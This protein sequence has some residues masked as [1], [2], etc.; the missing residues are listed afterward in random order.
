MLKSDALRHAR[1]LQ[2][3]RP[4]AASPIHFHGSSMEPL[5]READELIVREA[6]WSEIGLGDVVV[7]RLKDKYPALRVVRKRGSRLWLIGDNWPGRRFQL[8]REH[9]LGKVVARIRNGQTTPSTGAY[10]QARRAYALARYHAGAR[11]HRARSRIEG[12]RLV[13]RDGPSYPTPPNLQINVSSLCNLKCRMCPYLPVHGDPAHQSYMDEATFASLMDTVRSIGAVHL[14]GSGEPMHNQAL[15]DFVRLIRKADPEVTIDLTTNGTMMN[16]RRAR[17][18]VELGVDKLHVSFDGMPAR[19]GSIRTGMN[20]Q[21]VIE[22]IARLTEIKKASG[23]RRPAIQINY[24]TGYGT[25]HDLVDFVELANEIGVSEIQLLEMQPATAEDVRENLLAG[26]ERDGGGALKE[27]I[28]LA[29]YY[30]I[31]LHL[32]VVSENA[33][34]YPSN[35]HIGEDGEVYPCCYLDYDGRD[36]YYQGSSRR[37]PGTSF[38]NALRDSF[39]SIWS[40]EPYR[41][42]RE[43]NAKGDFDDHCHTCYSVRR[44]TSD[45][46]CD[47]LEL[48]R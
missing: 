28:M 14:S 45:R 2:L 18:L 7:Y 5:L 30:A 1:E 19:V 20:P 46:L 42:F 12:A 36:L 23:K 13:R 34:H 32:P 27:A 15:F 47:L 29:E 17:A 10:W 4:G 43:R 48:E 44:A 25:Y 39:Q 8:W 9:V 40:S 35:P 33:C 11:L 6:D 31:S 37:L 16:A 24:M 22:N 26:L 3:L 41:A 38:G 21:R